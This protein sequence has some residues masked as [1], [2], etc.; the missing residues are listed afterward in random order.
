[1][2]VILLVYLLL[3]C[4][5]ACH[6]TCSLLFIYLKH[7]QSILKVYS[8]FMYTRVWCIYKITRQNVENKFDI[9]LN[10]SK[11]KTYEVKSF[12][13]GENERKKCTFVCKCHGSGQT[14]TT[15]AICFNSLLKGLGYG[16]ECVCPSGWEADRW[17][18][19]FQALSPSQ[20][21]VKQRV[22]G[23]SHSGS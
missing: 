9:F 4:K 3:Y 20:R 21:I 17:W 7:T 15:S 14:R 12:L 23:R 1:M 19:R 18:W 16:S 11:T 22:S 10:I 6:I 5:F 8:Y 13:T 2:L